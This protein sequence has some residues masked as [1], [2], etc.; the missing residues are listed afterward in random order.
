MPVDW[1]IDP[2]DRCVVGFQVDVVAS[3]FAVHRCN[4]CLRWDSQVPAPEKSRWLDWT[5]NLLLAGSHYQRPWVLV[6]R[7]NCIVAHTRAQ[8]LH[9]L[10]LNFLLISTTLRC[11]DCVSIFL[12]YLSVGFSISLSAFLS[13][14]CHLTFVH[15]FW[16]A[17]RSFFLSAGKRWQQQP[18]LSNF[19]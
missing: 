15:F 16:L 4:I 12:C 5:G 11:L 1:L 2:S 8:V 19:G 18:T 3:T 6:L 10:V 14:Y 9:L 17:D 7:Y 13:W